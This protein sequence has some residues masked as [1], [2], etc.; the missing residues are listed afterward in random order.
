M[1][2]SG[3]VSI[4]CG[5]AKGSE[6]TVTSPGIY[7]QSDA[8]YIDSGESRTLASIGDSEETYFKT[9]RSFPQGR[10]NCYTVRLSPGRG[11]KYLIRASFWYGNYDGLNE[12]PTFELNLGA[13]TWSNITFTGNTET[14]RREIIHVLSSDYIHVCL[15]KTGTTIPFISALEF[16]PLNNTAYRSGSGSLQ[17]L[18]RCDC[19]EKPSTFTRYNTIILTLYTEHSIEI[20]Q[21]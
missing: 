1:S 12:F 2:P 10:K 15:I 14:V 18:Q 3:F 6:Y 9:L 8:D 11:N 13:D 20:I 4:D 19:A 21:S 7:Y 5:L 16:R 17:T